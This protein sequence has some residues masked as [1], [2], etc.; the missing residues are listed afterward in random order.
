[1]TEQL[2]AEAAVVGDWEQTFRDFY[3]E[4]GAFK[5]REQGI[6][7]YLTFIATLLLNLREDVK[8]EYENK[9]KSRVL[10]EGEVG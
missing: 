2:K 8:L 3:W 7:G 5:G 10:D 4:Q 6:E 9:N 1:M